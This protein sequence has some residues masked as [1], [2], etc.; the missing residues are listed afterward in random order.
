MLI[1]QYLY[2]GWS[3]TFYLLIVVPSGKIDKAKTFIVILIGTKTLRKIKMFHE[4]LFVFNL[5]FAFLF[6]FW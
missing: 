6:R 3:L 5:N 1:R 2:K 4:W